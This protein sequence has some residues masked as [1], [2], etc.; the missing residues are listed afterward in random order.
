MAT[1]ACLSDKLAAEFSQTAGRSSPCLQ[2][3]SVVRRCHP[4]LASQADLPAKLMMRGSPRCL[5][6]RPR[7][8]GLLP[9]VTFAAFSSFSLGILF[10]S[11]EI[12]R[13]LETQNRISVVIVLDMRNDLSSYPL[14]LITSGWCEAAHSGVAFPWVMLESARSLLWS[15]PMLPGVK[16]TPNQVALPSICQP[17]RERD[18]SRDKAHAE[19]RLRRNYGTWRNP[20]HFYQSLV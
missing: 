7:Q 15:P 8:P 1:T 14:H 20:S 4:L 9:L 17:N 13:I 3:P 2:T 16:Q 6:C 12:L 11:L 5:G 19:F 18:T 10:L